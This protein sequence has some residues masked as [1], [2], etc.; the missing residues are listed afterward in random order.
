MATNTS[1]RLDTVSVCYVTK[2]EFQ[3][4][5]FNVKHCNWDIAAPGQVLEECNQSYT[6]NLPSIN[7]ENSY[8][9][10]LIGHEEFD[11]S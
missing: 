7:R 10:F 8:E 1:I 9:I 4:V 5:P 6:I 11:V 2:F 3:C